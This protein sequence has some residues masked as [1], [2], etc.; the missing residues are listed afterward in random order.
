MAGQD[1][2]AYSL[3]HPQ[4]PHSA[5]F[6]SR[7]DNPARWVVQLSNF[8]AGDVAV[9]RRLFEAAREAV[10]LT[11]SVMKALYAELRL[12]GG[13][14]SASMMPSALEDKTFVEVWVYVSALVVSLTES[15]PKRPSNAPTVITL[16][17]ASLLDAQRSNYRP[18]YDEYRRRYAERQPPDSEL[19]DRQFGRQRVLHLLFAQRVGTLWSLSPFTDTLEKFRDVTCETTSDVD[20]GLRRVLQEVWP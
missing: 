15:W 17:E 8:T 13:M 4:P 18:Q 19:L 16:L 12:G 20:A 1:E 11:H 14:F 6:N 5:K 10:V 2:H 3:D 9:S 7:R